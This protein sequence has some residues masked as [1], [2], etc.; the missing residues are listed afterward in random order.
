MGDKILLEMDLGETLEIK[1]M[2]EVGAGH[3]IG[4][5]QVI[6]EVTTKASVTVGQ[7]QVQE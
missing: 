3:M 1:A 7:G 4:R 6:T 5:L 2:K